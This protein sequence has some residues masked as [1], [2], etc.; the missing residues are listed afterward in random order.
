MM[1]VEKVVLVER[2]TQ[3]LVDNLNDGGR[4]WNGLKISS[5]NMEYMEFGFWN[6]AGSDENGHEVRF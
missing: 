6:G 1:F 5:A 3:L 4:Y 2:N